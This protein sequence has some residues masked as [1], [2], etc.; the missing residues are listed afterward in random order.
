MRK[1]VVLGSGGH[2]RVILSILDA[3][4]G[5]RIAE[6]IELGTPRFGEQIMGIPVTPNPL[7]IVDW[8]GHSEVD[9]F[10]A[11][12]DNNLRKYWWEKIKAIGL[13]MPNLISPQALLDSSSVLGESNVI[14]ARAF[15]GPQAILG[16][17]NLI[18]TSAIVEHEVIVGSHCHLA[19]SSTVAG[20]GR[21]ENSCFL[22]AGSTVID[23]I[24]V[25]AN[26]IVGAGGTL[27]RNVVQSDGIYLGT[28]AKRKEVTE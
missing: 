21:I 24:S 26:T 1:A 2:C 19:P 5:Y 20:R 4:G 11:I 7:G 13:S 14:C 17:N 28:P 16:N 10:L 18:N 25:A 8:C 15:I 27:V 9:F 6:I 23:N 12:G 22:G 3:V